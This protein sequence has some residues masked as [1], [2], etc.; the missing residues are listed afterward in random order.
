MAVELTM[1]QLGLTMTEG[2]VS[3][4]L[5]K[6]GDKLKQGDEVV[7]VETD[8]INNIIEAPE[9]GVLIKIIA[10]EGAILPVKG[11]LGYI[12]NENEVVAEDN[13]TKRNVDTVEAVEKNI[14]DDSKKKIVVI[15][16]GP[17]G[18]VTAIRAAQLGASVSLVEENKL[19]GTCLN[20]GCIPTKA[21]IHASS[22][23]ETLKRD[24]ELLGIQVS[25][26][27]IDWKKTSTYKDSVV[28]RLVKGVAGLLAANGIKVYKGHAE[29]IDA[30]RVEVD[31]EKIEADYI[32]IAS[33]SEPV[34][35]KIPGI[36]SNG[37]I[38]S[39][40]ALSLEE[41]PESMIIIGGGVIGIE[42]A[43]MFASVGVKCT[44]V[45][46]LPYILPPIDKEIV[47]SV[48]IDLEQRGIEVLVNTK[49]KAVIEENGKLRVQVD[50]NGEDGFITGDKIVVAVG[51]RPK[52]DAKELERV[53]VK[54]ERGR[55]VTDD[56]FRTSVPSI[57]AIGDCNGKLM[58]AHAA[59]AQ[60]VAAVENIMTG[61]SHYSD[62]AVPSCIYLEPEVASV[63]M[64]EEDVQAAGIPYNVGKFS[65]A[66]NG[67]SLIENGGKGLIKIIADKKYGE[68]LG[69]HLY[70][71]HVTELISACVLAI[72]LEATVDELID[73]VW[74]H[75]S[76]SESIGEAAEAVC[77]NAIHWPPK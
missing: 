1:P 27:T 58:L 5:K 30:H 9:D 74:A 67:K 18:Y 56:R 16:G 42:F 3:K 71:P 76:V 72:Q 34:S 2:T 4:W 40:G 29:V 37:V 77:G 38:D 31:G 23:Y 46:A 10:E 21:L 68:I 65:L 26:P 15:G 75:P 28:N 70:G 61:K 41:L 11:I 64:K 33:G 12:G 25:A 44:I 63:G 14:S 54:T 52:T 49:V 62:K 7:E 17:G 57:F 39:T 55:I 66:G 47:E 59:S 50:R 20:V 36:D 48:R 45:E 53:G 8:K 6:A 32:I 73:S 13:G 19:G 24:A 43:S 35:L 60:G 51:R 22:A 69:V